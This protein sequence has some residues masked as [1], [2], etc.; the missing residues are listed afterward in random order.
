MTLRAH[1]AG[2]V[3][4][5]KFGHIYVEIRAAAARRPKLVDGLD[6]V[7]SSTANASTRLLCDGESVL[8]RFYCAR[9]TKSD[10]A[11]PL[12][13]PF[14][15][16]QRDI[17]ETMKSAFP[18]ADTYYIKKLIGEKWRALDESD[19][20]PYVVEA[21]KLN[22]AIRQR[23][24]TADPSELLVRHEM[25][26]KRYD[27]EEEDDATVRVLVHYL[28]DDAFQMLSKPPR[29][30]QVRANPSMAT[31]QAD[32]E[33]QGQDENSPHVISS[34]LETA[35]I[36]IFLGCS[37]I[38]STTQTLPM[39]GCSST[40]SC[41]GGVVTAAVTHAPTPQDER[42]PS[43]TEEMR[44]PLH[45]RQPHEPPQLELVEQ[46]TRQCHER[47]STTRTRRTL[48]PRSSPRLSRLGLGCGCSL[49]PAECDPHPPRVMVFVH[50]PWI[51]TRFLRTCA[52]CHCTGAYGKLART[53][54]SM[55][56]WVHTRTTHRRQPEEQQTR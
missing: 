8:L 21:K 18:G 40:S 43:P 4:K 17:Y 56:H 41:S 33:Q 44:P 45:E 54:S 47:S 30:L 25:R 55:R 13:K 24:A 14:V 7:P 20:Q 3:T 51:L 5:P 46:E 38:I 27:A 37:D 16:Y 39:P 52:R 9:R 48:R 10:A 19:K 2:L 31:T 34:S 49:D 23:M 15:L 6:W 53:L 12:A 36:C 1:C 26:L 50:Y 22:F 42:V 28:G 11:A 35:Q 32:V 29:P